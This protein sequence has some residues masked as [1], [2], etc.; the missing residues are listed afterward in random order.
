[1]R[2]NEHPMLLLARR[3]EVRLDDLASRDGSPLRGF[4]G[5]VRDAGFP[6]AAATW[7]AASHLNI[8][9][10][11]EVGWIQPIRFAAAASD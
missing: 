1:M 6:I 9:W 8:H 5:T 3:T 2:E 10:C 11:R 4:E 7:R